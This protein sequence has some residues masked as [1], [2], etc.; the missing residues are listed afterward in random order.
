VVPVGK[1]AL[2]RAQATVEVLSGRVGVKLAVLDGRMVNV[3]VEY[4]DVRRAAD[5]LGLPVKEVLRAAS[6]AAYEQ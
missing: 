1:V 2:E 6:S 4:E 5:A 3:S